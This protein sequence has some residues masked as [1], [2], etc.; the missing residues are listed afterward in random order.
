MINFFEQK[1][2][3]LE[4]LKQVMRVCKW[5]PEKG[6]FNITFYGD[7]SNHFSFGYHIELYSS[8]ES[9]GTEDF[10]LDE[11]H[12]VLMAFIDLR[13]GLAKNRDSNSSFSQVSLVYENGNPTFHYN[14]DEPSPL[15]P[16]NMRAALSVK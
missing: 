8:N 7:M 9:A 11:N 12:P 14:F 5:N 4:I 13:E 6:F 2:L 10:N 3:S 1:E 16:P 15:W